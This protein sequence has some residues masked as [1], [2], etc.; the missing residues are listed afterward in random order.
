MG[1]YAIARMQDIEEMSD[2]RCPYRPV[3]HHLGITT[4]G[5]T[6]WTARAAGDRILNEHDE[7]EPGPKTE[8]FFERTHVT[9][10]RSSSLRSRPIETPA[11]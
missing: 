9:L 1:G 7:N 3:R 6:T 4:F 2:G 8:R 5:A 10:T 11:R